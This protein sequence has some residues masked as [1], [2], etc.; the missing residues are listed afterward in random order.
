MFTASSVDSFKKE[1]IE[2]SITMNNGT[3]IHG[4]IFVP[5]AY[6]S[7]DFLNHKKGMFIPIKNKYGKVTKLVNISHISTMEFVAE[8]PELD[9]L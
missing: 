2:V 5:E 7:S 1:E 8:H 3:V 4:L 6:R 9:T